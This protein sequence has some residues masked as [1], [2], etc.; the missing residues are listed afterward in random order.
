MNPI[1][2]IELNTHFNDLER[3]V[4]KARR[5]QG[6][7]FDWLRMLCR[8][9]RPEGFENSKAPTTRRPATAR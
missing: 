4:A 7:V 6:A 1:S 5:T 9:R 8:N 2:Q 3:R